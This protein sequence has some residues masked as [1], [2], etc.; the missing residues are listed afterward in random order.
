M[1]Y[2]EIA[3]FNNCPQQYK[4]RKDGLRKQ[5]DTHESNDRIW[6]QAVHKGLESHYQGKDWNAVKASFLSLYPSD[7]KED[8]RAKSVE[9]GLKT[10]EAYITYYADQD[11]QWKVLG[12]EVEDTVQIGDEDHGLHVDL[13]A[14]HIPSQSIYGWD[15]KTTGKQLNFTY[16]KKYELDAQVTRYTEFITQRY[17]GCAGFVINGIAVGHRLRAYKGEPAGFWQK[18]ERQV[19]NRTREQIEF[20]KDSDQKWM[21]IMEW[22]EKENVWP[23]NLGSLCSWCEFNA[24]CLASGDEQIRELMYCTNKNSEKE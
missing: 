24:L 9:S 17:G 12:T 16:W 7:L 13:V 19:F 21:R 22:C 23:K 20:W 11:K 5:D 6:G 2:S 1:R 4:W 8:D 14:M 10:L 18:F 15:H 3:S